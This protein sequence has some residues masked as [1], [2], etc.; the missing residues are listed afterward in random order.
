LSL[1]ICFAEVPAGF[2]HVL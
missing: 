1:L 2:E